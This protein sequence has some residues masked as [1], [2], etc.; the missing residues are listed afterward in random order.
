MDAAIGAA[1]FI[2]THIVA[3]RFGLPGRGIAYVCDGR[4]LAP[5][6]GAHAND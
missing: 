4:N 5:L 2:L 1:T 3:R 6:I